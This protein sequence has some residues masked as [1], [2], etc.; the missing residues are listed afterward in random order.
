MEENC[1]WSKLETT[2]LVY[3]S[4]ARDI[5]RQFIDE[6]RQGVDSLDERHEGS[7]ADA[8][9]LIIDC[10]ENNGSIYVCGNGGSAADAQHIA[11]ELAGR[12]LRDRRAL[13]CAA[14]TVNASIL[15]AV[16]NDYTFDN[17]FSRQVEGSVRSGDVLWAISTSGVSRNILEAMKTAKALG[18]KILGFTGRDGGDM[19]PLCDVCFIAPAQAT[20][21]IQQL[22][23]IAYHCVCDLV[24]RAFVDF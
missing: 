14:L 19:P 16:G 3:G 20:Y 15:T 11:A 12:F 13:P 22:H 23:Q 2:Q 5:V 9:Q 4:T 18:A 1:S 6:A 17:I 7:L 10:Y 8:A 21:A 24:E